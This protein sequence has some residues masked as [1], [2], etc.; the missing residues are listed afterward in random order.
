MIIPISKLNTKRKYENK[1][2]KSN[3]YIYS[4]SIRLHLP[5]G[6]ITC[7]NLIKKRDYRA[8]LMN[9]KFMVYGSK[10]ILP[11]DFHVYVH[12]DMLSRHGTRTA[13]QPHRHST[14]TPSCC[15][16]RVYM[17]SSRPKHDTMELGSYRASTVS[18]VDRARASTAAR[19]CAPP[20]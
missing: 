13:R 18:L 4:Y 6:Q 16:R 7:T 11:T 5:H 1:Y 10:A 9:T 20:L 15:A 14:S 2:R 19:K 17:L 12:S 3:I 8:V